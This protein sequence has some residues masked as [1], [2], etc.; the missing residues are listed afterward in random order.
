[1]HRIFFL[2]PILLLSCVLLTAQEQP[3]LSFM[4]SGQINSVTQG[5]FNF[6]SPYSGVNSL[7]G[8]GQLRLCM[9]GGK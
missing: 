1:M 3:P 9:M 5:S 6:H 2:S 7:P 4:V 8:N